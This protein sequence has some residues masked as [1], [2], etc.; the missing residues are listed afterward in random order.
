MTTCTRTD[1]GAQAPAQLYLCRAHIEQAAGLIGGVDMLLDEANSTIAKQG[2]S[3]GGGGGAA[4]AVSS[5][6]VNLTAVARRDTLVC[7]LAMAGV[8]DRRQDP[9]RRAWTL[10]R[11]GRAGAWVE[12]IE[13]EARS[14]SAIID[15][16]IEWRIL[17]PCGVEACATGRYRYQDGDT[18]AVCSN[19]KCRATMG[20]REY[21]AWQ[22]SH[23]RAVPLRLSELVKTL[24]HAGVPIRQATARQWVHRGHLTAVGQ[25]RLGRDLYTADQLLDRLGA[26]A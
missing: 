11:S 7:A 8:G 10:A 24:H 13:A 14:L 5:A 2:T 1:C 6:P 18:I 9:A 22:L 23:A 25:D 15:R 3:A 21:R 19:R 26:A 4:A 12:V 16:P 20:I 17:G